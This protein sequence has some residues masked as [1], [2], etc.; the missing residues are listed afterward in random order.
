MTL[1]LEVGDSIAA[2]IASRSWASGAPARGVNA[3]MCSQ[4]PDFPG[5]LAW[6]VQ[7]LEQILA[8]ATPEPASLY[9]ASMTWEVGCGD[10]ADA[11]QILRARA[12]AVAALSGRS[13]R[14]LEE[15]LREAADGAQSL[16]NW[17]KVAAQALQ[18]CVTFFEAVRD[19]ACEALLLL[20]RLGDT[21]GGVIFGSAPWDLVAKANA[22][23]DFADDVEQ[24]VRAVARAFDDAL[25]A[26]R[27][28]VRLLTDLYRAVIP[29]HG[30]IDA[31]L[32]A[33][34]SSIPGGGIPAVPAGAGDGT[35]GETY[36]V[37][38]HPFPGSDLAFTGSYDRGYLHSYDLGP[39]DLTQE[40]LM[41]MFQ[42]EFGHL[43]LPSRVGDNSQISMQLTGPGQ[44]IDTSLFGLDLRG[45]TSGEITVAQVTS[46]GFRIAA[47][48]GHPEYPGEVAFH[49]TVQNGRAQLQVAGAY[50]DTIIGSHDLGAPVETNPAY[51]FIADTTIWADM[52]S[53]IEDRLRY[54]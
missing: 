48:P 28:L 13:A 29:V 49:L 37:S 38:G 3:G 5:P 34:L 15:A 4:V 41:A 52:S 45:I 39:T 32:G 16:S 46:D 1:T 23:R 50:D 9:A 19:L 8:A 51:A 35:F 24:F 11:A 33:I 36:H 21:I 44:T 25:Q 20:S 6:F 42:S 18:L 7:P 2:R 53:R 47:S 43:F 10:A 12:T 27:D 22:I 54:G 30:V 26:A 31:L 40:Q 17:A 14:A